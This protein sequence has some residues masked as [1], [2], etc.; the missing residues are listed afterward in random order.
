MKRVAAVLTWDGSR[1]PTRRLPARARTFLGPVTPAARLARTLTLDEPL[2]LRI[3]WVPRL[4]GGPDVLVPPFSTKNGKR[5]A[6][7]TVRTVPFGDMLG[8]VYRRGGSR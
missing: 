3:C 6:F 2:E 1:A 4:Q 5:I 7:R 8:V